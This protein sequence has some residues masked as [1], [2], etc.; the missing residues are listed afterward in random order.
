MQKIYLSCDGF[1]SIVSRK[2]ENKFELKYRDGIKRK[3]S[4]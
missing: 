2:E 3:D 4:R 1:G